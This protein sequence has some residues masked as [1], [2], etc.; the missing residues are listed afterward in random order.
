MKN[1][2]VVLLA[3]ILMTAFAHGGAAQGNEGVATDAQKTEPATAAPAGEIT[4]PPDAAAEMAN[5]EDA[6]VMKPVRIELTMYTWL[7]TVSTEVTTDDE[8]V[9]SEVDLSDILDAMDFANFAH[10]EVVKGKWGM[11]S[12]LDFVKLSNDTEIRVPRA[13]LVQVGA[14]GVIKQTMAELGVFRT[15]EKPRWA[16]DVFAGARYIRLESDVHAG[17]LESSITKDWLDPM[18]GAR[19]RLHLSEKWHASLGGDLAGFGVGS[20][21]ELTTNI[22]GVFSYDISD[23]YSVRFGYRYLDIDYETDAAEISMTT[24]G[25]V[26][27]MAIRF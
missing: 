16:V 4:P 18:L 10:L 23:R 13:P 6:K 5:P 1:A 20:G 9:S 26:L 22:V 11:F 15:F 19:L 3:A 27:G 17:F 24:S 12:E 8:E 21:S 14:D 25:P 7:P 2:R